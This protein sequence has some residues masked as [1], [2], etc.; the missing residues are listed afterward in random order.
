MTNGK[1]IGPHSH[2]PAPTTSSNA[3]SPAQS[4]ASRLSDFSLTGEQ[5]ADAVADLKQAIASEEAG[6]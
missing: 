5:R 2:T 6:R 4:A 1:G 3:S